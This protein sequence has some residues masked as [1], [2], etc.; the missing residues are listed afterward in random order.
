[1]LPGAPDARVT[2]GEGPQPGPFAEGPAEAERA[3]AL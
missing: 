2:V 3:P 1:M